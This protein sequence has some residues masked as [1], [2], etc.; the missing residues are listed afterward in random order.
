MNSAMTKFNIEKSEMAV[1]A[2]DII[3]DNLPAKSEKLS[4][5]CDFA[6]WHTKGD[7]F[8]WMVLADVK[9]EYSDFFNSCLMSVKQ[10]A[11]KALAAPLNKKERLR[12]VI[13]FLNPFLFASLLR[14][15]RRLLKR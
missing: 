14:L 11:G 4:A 7:M 1:K 10:Y 15:R 12:A 3:R 2:I 6:E 13:Q 9:D 5:A 8:N